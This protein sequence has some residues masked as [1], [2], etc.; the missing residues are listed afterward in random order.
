MSKFGI[1]AATA[2]L[3]AA[4]M[5]IGG[6]SCSQPSDN[7]RGPITTDTIREVHTDTITRIMPVS[8]TVRIRDTVTVILPADNLTFEADSVNVSLPR[9]QK[10]YADSN[11]RA[12][13]SGIGV[14]LDTIDIFQK[15]VTVTTSRTRMPRWVIGP[16]VGIVWTGKEFSPAV[17]ISLTYR[18]A[19]F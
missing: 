17:G 7:G 13:V 18:F 6:R 16:S 19:A 4:T 1:A 15:T 11:Y 9:E 8:K 14:S 3:T 2:A 5:V 12:V 10:V